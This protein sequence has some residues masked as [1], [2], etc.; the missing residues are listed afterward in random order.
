MPEVHLEGVHLRGEE[1]MPTKNSYS[2]AVDVFHSHDRPGG[3][4][5][6]V[7]LYCHACNHLILAWQPPTPLDDLNR[8]TKLHDANCPKVK[9]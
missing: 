7:A 3:D 6:Q 4:R 8:T 2:I 1:M 5:L 9:R